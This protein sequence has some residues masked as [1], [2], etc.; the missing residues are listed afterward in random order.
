[1]LPRDEQGRS[2]RDLDLEQRLFKYPV[3]YIIYSREFDTLPAYAK[4]YVY[5]KLARVLKSPVGDD[6]HDHLSQADREAALEILVATKADFLAY[7]GTGAQ[8]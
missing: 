5:R 8:N 1:M 6:T 3:S 2:L 4:D 7:T